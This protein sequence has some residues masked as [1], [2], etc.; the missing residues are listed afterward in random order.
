MDC[1]AV[2]SDVPQEIVDKY[3]GTGKM[4]SSSKGDCVN[5]FITLPFVVGKTFEKKKGKYVDTH[6]VQIKYSAKGVHIFPTYSE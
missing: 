4:E 6:T 2:R 3:G 5:E 1:L